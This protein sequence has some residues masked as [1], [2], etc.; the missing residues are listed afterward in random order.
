L[1]LTT[2]QEQQLKT[3]YADY[4]TKINRLTG[5]I[6]K[7]QN[8]RRRDAENVLTDEQRSRLREI[9]D[10]IRSKARQ[11]QRERQESAPPPVR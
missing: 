11:R 5:E 8:A 1:E 2:E 7:L 10:D 6:A 9:Q 4:Q 3:L